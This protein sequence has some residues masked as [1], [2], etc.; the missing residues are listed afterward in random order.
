MVRE[1]D[2]AK[3]RKKSTAE[4]YIRAVIFH[5]K[6]YLKVFNNT[7]ALCIVIKSDLRKLN[8]FAPLIFEPTAA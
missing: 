7:K 1:F 8:K 2:P 4:N 3:F 5:K 6:L